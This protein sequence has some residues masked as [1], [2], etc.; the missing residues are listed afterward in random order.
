M[1]RRRRAISVGTWYYADFSDQQKHTRYEQGKDEE[2]I[3]C[4]GRSSQN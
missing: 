1:P 4:M 2:T 3:I